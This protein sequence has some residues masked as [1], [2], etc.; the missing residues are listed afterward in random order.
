[1]EALDRRVLDGAVHALDLAVGPGMLKLEHLDRANLSDVAPVG[2]SL[3][4]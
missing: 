2:L 1:M 4:V 3:R